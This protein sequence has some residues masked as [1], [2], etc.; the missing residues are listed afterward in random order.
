MIMQPR[1]RCLRRRDDGVAMLMALMVIIL[2]S[3]LSLAVA[4]SI[5]A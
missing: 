5:L 1:L 3:T 4:G 2:A